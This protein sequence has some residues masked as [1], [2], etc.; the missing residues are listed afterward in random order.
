MNKNDFNQVNAIRRN[1]PM[2]KSPYMLA[3]SMLI[4]TAFLISA[5]GCRPK[6]PPV[7][8]PKEEQLP[9]EKPQAAAPAPKITLSVSPG[10]IEQGQSAQLT[11]KASNA[12]SVTID[13]G[14]GTVEAS[15]SRNVSPSKSTTY[16]ARATGA[17]GT[18]VAEAR[19]TVTPKEIVTPIETPGLKPSEIF[20]QRIK[21]AFFDYDQ[22]S[23]R[24]DA[25]NAL[26]EDAKV[27]KELPEIRIT[28]QG[29]ADER[30]SEKY[31]LAL[32]DQRANS[33]KA[34]LVSQG[35][36]ASRIDTVSFGKEQSFCDDH[37]EEC[38]QQNRRAHLVMR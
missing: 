34:F 32:G 36:D 25:Q 23:I 33:A 1:I 19:V 15:G 37:T 8:V 24:E 38:W 28:I 31:N 22:T 3:A 18:A 13:N 10:A 4:L 30:G 17:G 11:W 5:S 2:R 9:P 27:L 20:D 7:Q 6:K 21:D 26:K 29:Y 35:I 16:L 14:V 12:D